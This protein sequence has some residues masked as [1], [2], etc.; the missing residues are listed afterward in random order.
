MNL[1]KITL[2]MLLTL[3]MILTLT[4]GCGRTADS[5]A[6]MSGSN[7]SDSSGS[8]SSVSA[9]GMD[10]QI[11]EDLKLP[12]KFPTKSAPFY[13]ENG[14]YMIMGDENSETWSVG[15]HSKGKIE[16]VIDY[17]KKNYKNAKNKS[18]MAGEDGG[19]F[20]YESDDYEI[21]IVISA[22]SD[23]KGLADVVITLTPVG[24]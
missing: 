21:A 1:S 24:N 16:D 9:E 6:D 19:F 12:R 18:E 2:T 5:E 10:Y 8:S 7:S 20:F 17:Y 22:Q 13:K 3:F 14:I 23:E 11:G 4:A 15:Y